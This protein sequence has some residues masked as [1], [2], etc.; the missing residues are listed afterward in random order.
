MPDTAPLRLL[1]LPE[2][3]ARVGLRK[4]VIH[5]LELAGE[6]P[7]RVRI[8][9]RAAGWVESEITDFIR[10]RIADSRRTDARGA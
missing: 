4:S 10:A 6:F 8:S 1:R 2:V 9:T 3:E 5:K 7:R